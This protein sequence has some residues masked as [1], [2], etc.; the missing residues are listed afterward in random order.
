MA[1]S[2]Y[3]VSGVPTN[4]FS[5]SVF[6][7]SHGHKTSA[8]MGFLYPL[9]PIEVLPGDTFKGNFN[10]VCRLSSSFV[11]PIMDNIFIDLY[12]FFVPS[13]ILYDKFV[14]IFGENSQSA[15]ANSVEYELPTAEFNSQA[16]Q[17]GPEATVASHF[18][19]P[20]ASDDIPSGHIQVLPFRAFAKIYDEFFRD[21]NLCAPMNVLFGENIGGA[22]EIN[23]DEWAPNSYCGKVPRVAK[24]HDYFTSSLPSTQKGI[25]PSIPLSLLSPIPVNVGDVH[26]VQGVP[27]NASLNF[28]NSDGTTGDGDFNILLRNENGQGP[29]FSGTTGSIPVQTHPLVPNNLWADPGT[30]LT[31][32]TVN[33]LR[34]AFQVQKM[35][36]RDARSGSR[37]VEYLLGH[38]GV[39]S[40]DSRLQRP[41]FLGGKRIPI[42]VQQIAQTTGFSSS[43]TE[44]SLAQLGAYSLSAG[45]T[46]FTKSF[47][48]HGYIISVFCIRQFHSYQNCVSKLWTRKKRLDFYEPVFANI[49]EQPV[50]QYQI[51]GDVASVWK[52]NSDGHLPVFGYQE[53]WAEYRQLSNVITGQMNSKATDSLDFWHLGDDYSN[54][55]VLNKD[56]IEENYENLNRVIT[57]DAE[58]QDQFIIDFW[59]DLKAVRNMPTYS[60]PSLIDH[61]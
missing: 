17:S 36:E 32:M 8:S 47:V 56:F 18:G 28:I 60:V 53:A 59:E 21:E 40:G 23:S 57:V 13:R 2:S 3:I 24:M 10:L 41:E 1:K 61:N 35:L 52:E 50:Y 46:R 4:K 51:K 15:W 16:A 42:N 39:N 58:V 43:S 30:Y 9:D 54:P 11:K 26:T 38:W 37:Y 25:A 34:L 6:D 49:G 20:V 12:H 22:E 33:E 31:N 19:L 29:I 27:A 14:N 44:N 5:R 55:P 45:R 7:L 48:E